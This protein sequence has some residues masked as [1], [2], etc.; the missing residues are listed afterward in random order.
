MKNILITG[1]SSTI[2]KNLINFLLKKNYNIISH[3]NNNQ[4]LIKNNKIKY[5]R[6]NFLILDSIKNFT[7]FLINQENS[8]DCIIHL[9]ALKIKFKRFEDYDWTEIN[10]QLN[11]QVRSLHIILKTLIKKKRIS[12]KASIIILG[13]KSTELNSS[14]GML[15]YVSAKGLL[16]QYSNLLKRELKSKKIYLI[17]PDMFESPLLSNLPRYFIKKNSKNF[18]YR[19]K[20]VKKILSL[21]Y[22]NL[23]K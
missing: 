23:K 21:V 4:F 10:N 14:R 9:P 16:K 6:S 5:I 15:D 20:I 19:N 18:N 3:I 11:V 13:S 17:Y 22:K 12:E 8:F 2:G 1:G 7:N